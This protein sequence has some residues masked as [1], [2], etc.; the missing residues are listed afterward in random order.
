MRNTLFTLS[1]ALLSVTACKKKEE[2]K[3][4]GP[5][6]VPVVEVQVRNVTGYQSFPTS[7]Q[8]RVNNDVRAKI[9]GYITQVLVDEGQYVTKG[10]PLFRLETNTLNESADAARA[11]I[12]AAQS[13]VAAARANV[14]AAQ[15]AV[16]AAQ[17]EVNKLVPLVQKNIISN[18]QLETAKANLA[19]AQAQLSQAQAAQ[20][21]ANAGVSQ[22]SANYKGVQ[23]N[24]DYS[25]IRAPISGVVGKLPLRVGSLVGPSDPLPLTTVS[26]TSEIYAYFSMNEREYLDFLANSYGATLPEKIKNLPMVDLI[27]ANGSPYSEKGR[28][29]AVTGQ[30]DPQTGTIQFRVS[31]NNA[32]KLLSNGNSGTIRVPK[33]YNQALVVP[34][35]ATFEQQGLVYV[36]RVE[37]DT[38][39]NI[40]IGVT[41]RVNNLVVVKEGLKKGEKIVAQGVGTLKPR[42]AVKQKPANFD[43]IVNAIKPI[44]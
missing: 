15:A 36:F 11:G 34:E 37:Q 4:E 9:Q 8:G 26:D 13:G 29:Q 22:A 27:L 25:V 28:I 43:E 42:T 23:A 38:A 17:V 14:N 31:F 30:I 35:S 21:Q 44:F 40:L 2:T 20:Q 41:D 5:K 1:L 19:R 16:N 7:I 6:E 32:S 24:I 3:Q 12:G 33:L 18:V 10:Q 39:R